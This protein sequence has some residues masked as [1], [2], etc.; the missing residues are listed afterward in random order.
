L[1]TG[2]SSIPRQGLLGESQGQTQDREAI[3]EQSIQSDNQGPGKRSLP[4]GTFDAQ[5]EVCCSRV[6][7][8]ARYLP[9]QST[10]LR[11]V[12]GCGKIAD[13]ARCLPRQVT[14][15]GKLS[16][17]A[18]SCRGK[19]H[20]T[21]VLLC[22]CS[23]ASASVALWVLPSVRG[24]ALCRRRCPVASGVGAGGIGFSHI[25]DVQIYVP[26]QLRHEHLMPLSPAVR[27]R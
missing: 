15:R 14:L 6:L 20:C 26:G 23:S 3:Q 4:G 7:A 16:S 11:Q 24:R 17:A 18:R 12:I 2:S 13:T 9:R 25:Q 8:V 21:T 22:C 19:L 1:C 10:R 5:P 27:G